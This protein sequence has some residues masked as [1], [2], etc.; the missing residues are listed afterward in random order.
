MGRWSH[1][2]VDFSPIA[3][4]DKNLM[5]RYVFYVV[6]WA[7]AAAPV[8]MIVSVVVES[9]IAYQVLQHPKRGET[10]FRL[11]NGITT[12]L[13]YLYDANI[14]QNIRECVQYDETLLYKPSSGCSFNN[15]EYSTVL[16]FSKDGRG[17]ARVGDY[18]KTAIVSSAIRTHGVGC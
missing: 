8:L 6:L 11:W 3:M 2:I 9:G 13:Y 4:S 7:L 5:R 15:R 1:P 14:W 10:S 12:D 16:T 17:N 18:S